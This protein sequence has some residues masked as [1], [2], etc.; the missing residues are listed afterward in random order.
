MVAEDCGDVG[1]LDGSGRAAGHA[2][3]CDDVEG[4]VWMVTG[5]ELVG[6]LELA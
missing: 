3:L 5:T 6:S 2:W 4:H 1:S